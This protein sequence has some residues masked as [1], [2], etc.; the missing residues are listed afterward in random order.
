MQMRVLDNLT[1]WLGCA[2]EPSV[3]MLD[4]Y[5]YLSIFSFGSCGITERTRV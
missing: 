1:L 2:Q 4:E 3:L 5:R